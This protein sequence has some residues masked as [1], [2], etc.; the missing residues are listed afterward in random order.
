MGYYFGCFFKEKR[1]RNT[2]V[3][4]AITVGK[5]VAEKALKLG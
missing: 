3:D 5:L 1:K 4:V 2:N